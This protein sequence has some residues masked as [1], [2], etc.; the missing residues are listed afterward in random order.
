[1]RRIWLVLIVAAV[2]LSGC[3]ESTGNKA[4][5]AAGVSTFQA[6]ILEDGDVS[7][8][9]MELAVAAYSDCLVVLGITTEAAFDDV[10]NVWSYRFSTLSEDVEMLLNSAEGLACKAEYLSQVELMFADQVGP[11]PEED[12][13]FYTDIVGCMREKGHD[14]ENSDPSTLSA[15][16]D[17]QPDDYLA[18]FNEVAGL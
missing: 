13:Q 3:A 11:S 7:L 1:M 9:E 16:F 18:C 6:E 2:L 17:K 12:A 5:P 10:D 15:W 8:G 4:T 14:V